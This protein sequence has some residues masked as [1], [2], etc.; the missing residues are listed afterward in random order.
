MQLPQ[1]LK[2]PHKEKPPQG[3]PS[4]SPVL[5]P[6]QNGKTT[7]FARTVGL[8]ANTSPRTPAATAARPQV[9]DSFRDVLFI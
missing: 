9:V 2:N 6:V 7:G 1:S 5:Q 4:W 3:N 8:V